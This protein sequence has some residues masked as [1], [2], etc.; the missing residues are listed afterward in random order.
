MCVVRWPAAGLS[1]LTAAPQHCPPG[2]L[3]HAQLSAVPAAARLLL[4]PCLLLRKAF[5]SFTCFSCCR[6]LGIQLQ[7]SALPA[8]ALSL[9]QSLLTSWP[10][11]RWAAAP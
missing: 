11:E 10:L 4:V 2:T 7:N 9:S 8:H 3:R 1:G 6:S 5:L